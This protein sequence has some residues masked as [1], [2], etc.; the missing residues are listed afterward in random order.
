MGSGRSSCTSGLGSVAGG[1]AAVRVASWAPAAP[2]SSSPPTAGAQGGRL[3]Q[4]VPLLRKEPG[5]GE[6]QCRPRRVLPEHRDEELP[7]VVSLADVAQRPRQARE[8]VQRCQ[9]GQNVYPV[10]VRVQPE[11]AVRQRLELVEPLQHGAQVHVFELALPTAT[12]AGEPVELLL[13][14]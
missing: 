4:R 5:P 2:W 11:V 1:I 8:K 7:K 10:R 3:R 6:E 14:P 9:L 12:L 13:R